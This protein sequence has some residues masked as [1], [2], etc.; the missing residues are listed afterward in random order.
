MADATP[1][2][3][4]VKVSGEKEEEEEEAEEEEEEHEVPDDDAEAGYIEDLIIDREE[5]GR[6]LC[7][8]CDRPARVC[9]CSAVPADAPLSTFTCIAVLQH[10]KETQRAC[11]TVPLLRLC[12]KDL[13]IIVGG[14]MP[15]PEESTEVNDLLSGGRRCVLVCPGPGAVPLGRLAEEC[16]GQPLTLIFLDGRW[17]QVPMMLERSPWLRQL[18]RVVLSPPPSAYVFRQQPGRGLVS[19][20][21]AVAEALD[22]L[23]GNTQGSSAEILRNLFRCMVEQ[24]C[25]FIPGWRDKN[26]I[27]SHQNDAIGAGVSCSNVGGSGEEFRAPG[28]RS[29]RMLQE[30]RGTTG[31]Q[32]VT[33]EDDGQLFLQCRWQDQSASWDG[34]RG[35]IVECRLD[36]CGFA[37]ALLVA[38]VAGAGRPRGRR[39]WL[40]P[41]ARLPPD[42]IWECD[43]DAS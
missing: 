14:R 6:S 26:D 20:L 5:S 37:H 40:I 39:P 3:E 4:P 16:G 27:E 13:H 31:H 25:R 28:L 7:A 9:L 10:P 17:S 23:E 15:A 32:T 29:R 35:V 33:Q 38:K 19:T 34:R 41:L 36:G 30:R 43:A 12:L 8:H 18:P 1:D 21:E 24:Q 11:G 42:A 2:A 22:V